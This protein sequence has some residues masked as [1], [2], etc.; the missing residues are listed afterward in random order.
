MAGDDEAQLVLF[1]ALD[2]IEYAFLSPL[3]EHYRLTAYFLPYSDT[4]M[5]AKSL[6]PSITLNSSKLYTTSQGRRS[7][8]YL[9]VPRSRRTFTPAMIA[10]LAETDAAREKTSKKDTDVRAAE[11]RSAASTDLL[12]WVAKD[13]KDVSRDTGGSLVVMEVMLEADGGLLI[14]F[15]A[16]CC[17]LWR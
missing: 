16:P 11:V 2:V 3:L 15:S 9:L 8:L 7:L 6:I 10:S 12:A 5:L 14:I 1:T 13:G 17:V 4:K